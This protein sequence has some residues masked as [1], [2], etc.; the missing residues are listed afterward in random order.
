MEL[1]I[2]LKYLFIIAQLIFCQSLSNGQLVFTGIEK[3]EQ[4]QVYAEQRNQEWC[5]ASSIQFV[6]N[7]Y[8]AK[9]SQEDIIKKSFHVSDPYD[10]LPDWHSNLPM[11]IKRL[12]GWFIK[13]KGRKYIVKAKLVSEVPKPML[14]Y[15]ELKNMRP[16]I[17]VSKD[18]L[19]S[20]LPFI[21]TAVG[22]LPGYYGPVVKQI[23]IRSTYPLCSTENKDNHL[24]WDVESLP[25]RVKDY[26]IISVKRR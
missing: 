13:C 8:G 15:D 25:M 23:M 7:Y 21:C 6:L 12:N 17:L 20:F 16:V 22:F 5:W 19:K 4:N 2:K 26:C 9:V 1:N 18:S 11:I 14:L 10:S 24:I 3:V